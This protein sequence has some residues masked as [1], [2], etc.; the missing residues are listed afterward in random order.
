MDWVLYEIRG[1]ITVRNRGKSI[2][3]TYDKPRY[4]HLSVSIADRPP[5]FVDRCFRIDLL[6]LWVLNRHLPPKIP[7]YSKIAP[8]F[9]QKSVRIASSFREDQWASP[10]M[11][12]SQALTALSNIHEKKICTYTCLEGRTVITYLLWFI[13]MLLAY[14]TTAYVN[15]QSRM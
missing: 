4:A 6:V 5:Y 13:T 10:A 15:I 3:G 11:H 9:Q 12:S 1:G 8:S 14:F 2:R 7:S